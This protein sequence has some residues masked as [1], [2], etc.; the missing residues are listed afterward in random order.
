MTNIL[1]EVN[2]QM[3]ETIVATSTYQAIDKG[4]IAKLR[5]RPAETVNNQV[6]RNKIEYAMRLGN[7]HHVKVRLYFSAYEGNFW[8]ETTVWAC[9]SSSVCLK[10]GIWIPLNHITDVRFY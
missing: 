4:L 8:V 1:V 2:Q 3:M 7:A 5:F 6:L 9:D 10:G